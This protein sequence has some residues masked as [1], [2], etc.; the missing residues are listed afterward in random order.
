MMVRSFY[1][2]AVITCLCCVPARSQSRKAP[3][4]MFKEVDDVI[5]DHAL[6]IHDKQLF[7]DDDVIADLQGVEKVLNQPVK[8]LRNPILRTD[9]KTRIRYH[10]RCGCA[11]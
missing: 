2:C 4:G 10:L 5:V 6:I 7:I 11:R 8:H 1:L 9:K 3:P